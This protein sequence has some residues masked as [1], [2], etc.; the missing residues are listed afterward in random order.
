MSFQFATLV[1][2]ALLVGNVARDGDAVTHDPAFEM[3]PPE[4]AA[5][6]KNIVELTVAQLK[7]RYPG[8]NFVKRGVHPKDHGCVIAKFKVTDN[9]ADELRVGIFATPGREYQ[10]Y[11]RY[12]NADVIARADSPP[13]APGSP[14]VKHGSRGMAIKLLGVNGTPLLDASGPVTQDFLMVNQPVFAF[15]NVEDYEA[16]SKVLLKDSDD[17]RGFFIERIKRDSAGK[18]DVR[19]PMTRRALRTLEISG[20]VQSLSTT[21]T[22]PAYQEPPASPVDNTYFSAAPYQFGRDKAMKFRAKPVAP[23]TGVAPNTADPNYL[24]AALL[25]RLTDRD[26]KDIVFEFQVQVRSKA[27]LAGKIATEMEDAC[28]EW[29]EAKYPFVTVATIT[30]PPQDFDAPKQRV[31]CEDL[32][33]TPWHGISEHQP[34]GGINRLKLEVYKAS[35]T[36]RHVPKE[37]AGF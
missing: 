25:K 7:K 3:V 9:L 29:D 16:L 26:A 18:P 31:V 5:Q 28:F 2:L 35:A 24:R 21:A 37:P 36:F 20:R 6:I 17:P 23:A 22:P 27:D 15:S 34:L 30:I 32:M 19:I 12:S 14:T 1:S 13:V 33:F 10:A 8:N 4:E 11:I